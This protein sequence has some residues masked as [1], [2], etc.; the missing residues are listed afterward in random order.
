MVCNAQLKILGFQEDIVSMTINY[1]IIMFIID[2]DNTA[3]Q[4][5]TKFWELSSLKLR[6]TILT[7]YCPP[8][9]NG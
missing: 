8:W 9:H 6:E 2:N 4:G 3:E 5:I 1:V 7:A